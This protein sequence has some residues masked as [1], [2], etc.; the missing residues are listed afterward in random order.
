MLRGGALC[1]L[2]ILVTD[3]AAGASVRRARDWPPANMIFSDPG[4][5]PP[6]M[7]AAA[8]ADPAVPR[9]PPAPVPEGALIPTDPYVVN[10]GYFD[11]LSRVMT[12]S[13]PNAAG[14]GD[15]SSAWPPSQPQGL[16]VAMAG[17]PGMRP[18]TMLDAKG[19][20][21]A[22]AAAEDGKTK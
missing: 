15:P 2:L 21:Y 11:E 9:N 20:E 7:Q 14:T 3:G 22:T 5:A 8:G 19:G 6:W 18:L 12:P 10:S 1:A 13:V 16:P 17:I 4:K